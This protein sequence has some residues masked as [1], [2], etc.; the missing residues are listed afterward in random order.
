MDMFILKVTGSDI[1][2]SE[3]KRVFLRKSAKISYFLKIIYMDST[4]DLY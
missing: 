4:G 2:K 3:K 1:R